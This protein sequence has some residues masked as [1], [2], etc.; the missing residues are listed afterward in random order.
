MQNLPKMIISEDRMPGNTG[1]PTTPYNEQKIITFVK[2][3]LRQGWLKT[4]SSEIAYLFVTALGI[5]TK[6][7][8]RQKRMDRIISGLPN[9]Q[10][11]DRVRIVLAHRGEN[12]QESCKN[13]TVN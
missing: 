7:T 9:Y 10:K 3:S 6:I 13:S 2:I 11:F 8:Y 4:G 5:A 1:V 12:T